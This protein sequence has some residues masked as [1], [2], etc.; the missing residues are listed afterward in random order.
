MW[1]FSLRENRSM[2]KTVSLKLRSRDPFR[3]QRIA[4][5]RRCEY[6][7]K[8]MRREYKTRDEWFIFRRDNK[9]RAQRRE[10]NI[11]IR[12]E[13]RRPKIPNLLGKMSGTEL[14]PDRGEVTRLI[15][16]FIASWRNPFA[17]FHWK[18]RGETVVLIKS[19][20]RDERNAKERPDEPRLS[21]KRRT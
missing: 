2:G 15:N 3:M 21:A 1:R 7:L 8:K 9:F 17:L 5:I 12:R 20:A 4:R 14:C 6:D 16:L 11:Q 18:S 19:I 13:G 10:W